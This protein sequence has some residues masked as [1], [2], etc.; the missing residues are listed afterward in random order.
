V[1]PAA[2]V[3]HCA[4]EEGEDSLVAQRHGRIRRRSSSPCADRGMTGHGEEGR[5]SA[6][7]TSNSCPRMARAFIFLKEDGEG[8]EIRMLPG[9]SSSSM[10]PHRFPCSSLL[11]LLFATSS[12]PPPPVCCPACDSCMIQFVQ[13]VCQIFYQYD[14]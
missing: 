9:R 8:V 5:S 3:H 1:E 13:N 7:R 4:G 10:G 2:A 6:A 12:A 14:T 11:P